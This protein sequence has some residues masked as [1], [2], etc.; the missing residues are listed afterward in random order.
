MGLNGILRSCDNFGA[1]FSLMHEG[2]TSYK[3]L[4]GGCMSIQLRALVLTFFCMQLFAVF[5]RSDPIV[6]SYEVRTSRF[7]M[8]MISMDDI[9][10]RFFFGFTDYLR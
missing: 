4:A 6:S 7:D 5:N 1:P 10:M 3:T 2:Q 9:Q 8:D